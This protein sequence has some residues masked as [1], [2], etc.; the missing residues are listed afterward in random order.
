MM[1]DLLLLDI[2]SNIRHYRRRFYVDLP[3]MID[4]DTDL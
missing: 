2:I 4:Y 3:K 1:I